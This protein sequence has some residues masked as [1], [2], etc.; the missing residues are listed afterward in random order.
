MF[1][2]ENENKVIEFWKNFYKISEICGARNQDAFIQMED[3]G[4][5]QFTINLDGINLPHH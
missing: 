5:Y 2:S 3:N 1:D 4:F